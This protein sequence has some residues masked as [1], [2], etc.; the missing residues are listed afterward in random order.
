MR[1]PR[2]VSG[3]DLI[4]AL[5]RLGYEPTRQTGSHI[6]LT[7]RTDKEEYHLTIPEHNPLKIGTLHSILNR[8]SLQTNVSVENAY[9]N[10]LLIFPVMQVRVCTKN[11]EMVS[12]LASVK[13]ILSNPFGCA[14]LFRTAHH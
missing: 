14:F 10:A 3:Q 1:F 11:I 2:N 4:R 9:R 8:V 5:K 6:R 13:E 12:E 7:R